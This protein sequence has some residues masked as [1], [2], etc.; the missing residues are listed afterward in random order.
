MTDPTKPYRDA[1][2]S[3]Y[4][5]TSGLWVLVAHRGWWCRLRSIA[6][7]RLARVIPWQ[8]LREYERMAT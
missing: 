3:I 6:D 1:R 4:R 8:Q 2:M 5:D 7:I